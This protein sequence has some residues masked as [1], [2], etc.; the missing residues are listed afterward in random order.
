MI[1]KP[2]SIPSYATVTPAGQTSFT[3][4]ATTTDPRAL[5]TPDGSSRIAATW[6]SATSFTIA[7]NFNDGK[8]HNIALYA[9]DWDKQGRS[10]Q[11]QI[12]SAATGAIL[13]TET[14]SSFSSG[15]Y[16]QWKV[17]GSV[18][19]RATRLSGPN[20]VI[21]GLFF[22]S[23]DASASLVKSDSATEGNWLGA[24][25]SQGYDVIGK[26]ASIPSYATVTPAGQS[27]TTWATTTTDPRALQTPD[28]SSRIAATWYSSTSFTIAVNLNDGKAHNIALYALDWDNKGRSEQ[29]QITSAATGAILDTETISSF[30]SGEYLQWKVSG[31]VVIRVTCLSGVNAVISGVFFDSNDA[32]ASLVKSDLATKGNWLGAY[33]SQGYDVIGKPAGIPSYATVTPAGQSTTTW[34]TT[35]TDPRALQT[36]DGTSRIAATWYSST[37]FTIA[38]NL[39]D[40]K[41]HNIA[42][43][44]LDWDNKGR[45]EQIQITS[46]ATGA[47]LDTESISSFSSGEYLQW[48]VS[49]SIVI[50]VT[51]LSGVNAVVS[52]LFFDPP[53]A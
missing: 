10:E 24:Y 51:C 34:A 3:W 2:A 41:A 13:D 16:L 28:G 14:I 36:P 53:L 19:I 35:T 52:G 1:G 32:S 46:A 33:G 5:Q 27:T 49:G 6:Y 18:V 38:V 39:N 25:G 20:A 21:N 12:T 50:R 31:S 7:V 47:I 26:P 43:Y 29:I 40:G 44:A 11:I 17:S 30:S 15:E 42:L 4:A 9:L 37:S 45:S 48:K 8:A 22:D 23:G